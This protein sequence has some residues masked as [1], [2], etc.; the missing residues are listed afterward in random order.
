MT[1]SSGGAQGRKISR[2]VATALGIIALF[3]ALLSWYFF[4]PSVDLARYR[5]YELHAGD[6][7]PRN[8]AVKVTFLGTATLL[9]DDGETQIMTD[10]FLS[11]PGSRIILTKTPIKTDPAMVDAI[12]S[13]AKVDRLQALFP[14]HSHYDHV[15]DVAYIAQ[16][17]GAHLYGSPSTLNVG[18][19]GGLRED[20]M[21]L[22]QPGRARSFGKFSVTVLPSKHSPPTPVN[23]DIGQQI[24]APLAQPAQASDYKEGGSFDFLIRHGE[25]A[26]LVKASGNYLEGAWDGLRADVVFLGA[27]ALGK[28]SAAF[29]NTYYDQTIGKVHPQLV[30]PI[31][32]DNFLLPLSENLQGL[33]RLLDDLSVGFDF[34][35]RRLSEDKIEFGILQGFQS[36]MLFREGEA[37]K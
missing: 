19:G 23:N 31:H 18:R 17:T 37:Q 32:W 13:R 1:K 2:G 10:G 21:S 9:F 33:Y 29:Q 11:R 3:G 28:K 34:L 27:G 12:L 35:I 6:D 4:Q 7:A 15:M 14:A 16:R 36:V 5:R 8:G 25:H 30:I 26:I 24:A 22:Y 20:Q